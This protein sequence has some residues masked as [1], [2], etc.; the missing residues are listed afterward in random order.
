MVSS[1]SSYKRLSVRLFITYLKVL[2]LN[3]FNYLF[4]HINLYSVWFP[5]FCSYLIIIG[6]SNLLLHTHSIS[7]TYGYFML[8]LVELIVHVYF[9]SMSAF[10]L[11]M[12]YLKFSQING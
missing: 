12:L 7:C 8:S 2:A 10:L 11:K 1:I 6:Y 5:F 4:L 9:Y 3:L